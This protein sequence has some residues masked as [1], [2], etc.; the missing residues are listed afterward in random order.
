MRHAYSWRMAV[1]GLMGVLVFG[2]A[3]SLLIA[4]GLLPTSLFPSLEVI[5]IHL[6]NLLSSREFICEDL[7]SSLRRLLEAA[8]IVLPA[9]V[10]LA[11]AVART[12]ALRALSSPLIQFLYPLPKVALF[13]LALAVFGLGDA[14]KVAL[15][16]AGMF[17]PMYMCVLSGAVQVAQS[18]YHDL[19]KAFGVRGS[20]LY[21]LFYVRG[22]RGDILNGLK[23]SVGYGFTM[24]VVSEMTASNRGLG[25]FIWRSWDSFNIPDLYAGIVF[26]G[27]L[28][29]LAQ[30]VTELLIFS[31]WTS[32]TAAKP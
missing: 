12:D 13:P 29:W 22:V 10:I 4:S 28:G 26:L 8:L 11:L 17:F 7:L 18:E 1:L 14:A 21:Y 23:L 19:I 31:F 15:I 30:A 6:L 9:S 16:G 3:W 27:L 5:A 25:S 32:K 24:V 20:R 2:A